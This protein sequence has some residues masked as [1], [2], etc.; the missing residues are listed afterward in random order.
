MQED[1]HVR[2]RQFQPRL[3]NSKPEITT[4]AQK[5]RKY[6]QIVNQHRLQPILQS[7]SD[8]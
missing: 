4:A 8:S 7:T 5:R 2:A 1:Y 6:A 3:K